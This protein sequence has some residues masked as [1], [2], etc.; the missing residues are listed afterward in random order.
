[1]LL[2]LGIVLFVAGFQVSS[3]W[4]RWA[5]TRETPNVADF[6]GC[7]LGFSGVALVATAT[8]WSLLRVVS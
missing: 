1:M 5:R 3:R 7:A 8:V 6:V 2:L 4:G